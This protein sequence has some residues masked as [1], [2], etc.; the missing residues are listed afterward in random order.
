MPQLSVDF[1]TKKSDCTHIS[2]LLPPH[3]LD[4]IKLKRNSQTKT[5]HALIKQQGLQSIKQILVAAKIKHKKIQS[6][7]KVIFTDHPDDLG[8]M[9]SAGT[10]HISSPNPTF[11]FYLQVI[12]EGY[13]KNLKKMTDFILTINKKIRLGQ[14]VMN[15][16]N[17]RIDFKTCINFKGSHLAPVI[18]KDVILNGINV[19]EQ[20]E[21]ALLTVLNNTSQVNKALLL[22]KKPK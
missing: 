19:I 22:I 2:A 3:K 6:G 10:A 18:V 16:T 20:H 14:F 5:A 7:Y 8:K 11:T 21:N 4:P 9:S 17:G 13:V 1:L 15:D 12:E